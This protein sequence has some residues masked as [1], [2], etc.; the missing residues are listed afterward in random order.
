MRTDPL[1]SVKTNRTWAEPRTTVGS[2]Q[3]SGVK[4]ATPLPLPHHHHSQ[5]KGGPPAPAPTPRRALL[6]SSAAGSAHSFPSRAAAHLPAPPSPPPP[7]AF[8]APQM[9][10]DGGLAGGGSSVP[11]AAA[12]RSSGATSTGAP[13][14][15]EEG[16]KR[17]G[18]SSLASKQQS[19]HSLEWEGSVPCRAEPSQAGASLLSGATQTAHCLPSRETNSVFPTQQG[20]QRVSSIHLHRRNRSFP[21]NEQFIEN[22]SHLVPTSTR[23]YVNSFAWGHDGRVFFSPSP[24]DINVYIDLKFLL[25]FFYL[26]LPPFQTEVITGADGTH[27]LKAALSQARARQ[28]SARRRRLLDVSR[29]SSEVRRGNGCGGDHRFDEI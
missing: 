16:K 23:K 26:S 25:F 28:D 19:S 11:R 24:L 14:S 7:P 29:L 27:N 10:V 22:R 18:K 13:T 15:Q 21:S 4:P 20:S 17:A 8:P 2:A 12:A 6:A 5:M 3:L 1:R 9:L